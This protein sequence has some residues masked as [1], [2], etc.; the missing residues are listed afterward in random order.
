MA[1][2]AH[3]RQPERSQPQH[4]SHT[5]LWRRALNQLRDTMAGD[6]F[7]TW[8]ARTRAVEMRAGKLVIAV[9]N[10]FNRETLMANFYSPISIAVEHAAGRRV[11]V[12]VVVGDTEEVEEAPPATLETRS[13]APLQAQESA[14]EPTVIRTRPALKSGYTLD[15]FVVGA[16]NQIAYAAATAVVENPGRSHN[17]LFIH[18]DSGFGKT[19][20]LQGI[21]HVT[22]Q[23]NHFT[24]YISTETFVREYVRAVRSGDRAAFQDKYE[25]ADVLIIDDIQDLFDKERTQDEFF[26]LFNALHLA[27]KQIVLSSDTSPRR[28]HGLPE[29]LVT[30]FEW[31]LV[32]EI[33][34]PDLELRMAILRQKADERKMHVEDKVLRLLAQRASQNVRQLERMLSH[35]R[36]H[37]SMD[38]APITLD[39]A[40]RAIEDF[41]FD[42]VKRSPPTVGEIISATCETTSVSPEAFTTK[43]KDQ[44]AARAR[45]L[46]MYLAREHT[47]LSYKEIGVHFGDRDHTTVLHGYRKILK[48]VEGD[49]AKGKPPKAET[50]RLISEIR[51]RLRL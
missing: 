26:N 10:V 51:S 9:D 44:R 32:V 5:E 19:H 22:S 45:H 40:L 14:S 8:F 1:V 11:E 24:H 50:Q 35:V 33:T 39:L 4:L 49:E 46:A 12:D 15:S 23:A 17:P 47:G 21:A 30:R 7:N 6:T 25:Q 36:L 16:S 18:A 27:D 2:S 20:L 13:D 31:G 48:E 34:K 38:G 37:A 29:R 3:G 28:L 43:R 41:S 42:E